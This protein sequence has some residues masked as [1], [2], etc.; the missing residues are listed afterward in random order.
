MWSSQLEIGDFGISYLKF[1]VEIPGF[2]LFIF[3]KL[4]R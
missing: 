4:S 3:G 2:A 1:D